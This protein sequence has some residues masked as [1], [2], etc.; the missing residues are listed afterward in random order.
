MKSAGFGEDPETNAKLL[1]LWA[2]GPQ[3]DWAAYASAF[4]GINA[5]KEQGK[6]AWDYESMGYLVPHGSKMPANAHLNFCVKSEFLKAVQERKAPAF[7]D[8]MMTSPFVAGGG[9]SSR[10]HNAMPGVCK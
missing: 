4:T 10:A 6:S 2:Y 9:P 7:A 1:K 8:T 3:D 5:R